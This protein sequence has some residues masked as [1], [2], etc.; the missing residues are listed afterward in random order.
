MM[1]LITNPSSIQKIAGT[2]GRVRTNISDCTFFLMATNAINFPVD[3]DFNKKGFQMRSLRLRL[4]AKNATGNIRPPME[5]L[6][7]RCPIL[8]F[9]YIA[10]HHVPCLSISLS[11]SEPD[12]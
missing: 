2:Y 6:D 12:K 9:R 10:P 7:R 4:H 3:E 11:I 8:Q 5:V 1:S